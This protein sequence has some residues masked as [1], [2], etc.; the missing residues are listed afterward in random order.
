VAKAFERF[1]EQSGVEVVY[2][3]DDLDYGLPNGIGPEVTAM[4]DAGVDFISTCVDL[5]GMKTLAQELNRQGMD[6]VVLYHPNSYDQ[7]FVESSDGLFEGDV[8]SVQFRP[9]E[10]D[11][12]ESALGEFRTW[13]ERQD[14]P[15]SELAMV[16]WLNASLA[17]D[18]LLAAGPEFDRE[19]VVAATNALEG[20]TADGLL[21]P[22]DW[23]DAHTPYT[24]ADPPQ[25]PPECTSL[26]RVADGA[27]V[28]FGDAAK[29]WQCWTMDPN[30]EFEPTPTDFE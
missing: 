9:L 5:N 8:V 20:W 14:S 3:N 16:G 28:P 1:E 18:G 24:D 29:P 26:V 6:D 10:S 12:G 15:L 17:F 13:I 2:T 23:A 7:V 21:S 19:R 25:P 27:F 4:K 30:A 11:P 22:I